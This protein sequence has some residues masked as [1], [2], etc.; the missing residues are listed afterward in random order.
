M[1]KVTHMTREKLEQLQIDYGECKIDKDEFIAG[2][3]ELGISSPAELHLL[4]D[5][6]CEARAE[7]KL[8]K[9]KEKK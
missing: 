1:N 4:Y 2:V 5:D 7:Y 3:T 8:D 6:A 9:A